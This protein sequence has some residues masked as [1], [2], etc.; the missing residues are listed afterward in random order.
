MRLSTHVLAMATATLV[1]AGSLQAKPAW[2]KK[3]QELGFKDVQNCA[4]CHTAKPPALVE[5][6]KWLVE[7]KG[8]RKASS[9][10]LAWL[11]DY[12]KP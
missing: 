8:K 7:E 3:A 6:G 5:M 9:I 4:V 10:D 12:K 2:V 1:A 11:K